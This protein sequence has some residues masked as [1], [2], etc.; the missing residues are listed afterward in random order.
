VSRKLTLVQAIVDAQRVEMER[1]GKV[2][3]LGEDVGADGGVFRA[4]EGLLDRFGPQR[5]VDTPL[6]ESGIIG[7]S[8]GMALAGFRPVAEIQFMGFLYQGAA[9]LFSHAARF[10]NRTRGRLSVPLVVRTPYGGGIRAPEHHSES[11]EALLVNTPGLKVVIPSN[12]YDAK[13]L[14]AAAIR[15]DDPVVFMEPTSLYRSFR[16]E[17]P[18]E[19]YTVPLGQAR[20]VRPG[21]DVSLVTYGTMVRVCTDAAQVLEP[22]GVSAEVVDL[23]TIHPLD[24][25]TL[26]ASVGKT[27]RVVVVHEAPRAASISSEIAALVNE[28]ALLKLLAPVQRVTGYDTPFPLAALER[29]YLPDRERVLAAVR[30]TL[31]F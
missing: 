2:L 29:H 22:Q 17:V 20:V 12:P 3:V 7:F 24:L 19:P 6:A 13:G 8:V 9:Q 26:L 5:V 18:E 31:E 30:R 10:R 4:T 25:E 1:D 28:R 27:G 23:R 16:E 14:L 21:R 11:Y 15:D